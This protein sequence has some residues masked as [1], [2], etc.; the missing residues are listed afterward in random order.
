MEKLAWKEN[1]SE[2]LARQSE[3]YSRKNRFI[4][5]LT[6]SFSSANALAYVCVCFFL[7]QLICSWMHL[8]YWLIRFDMN[9]D[10][11]GYVGTLGRSN[12]TMDS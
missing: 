3:I 7:R 4:A 9:E 11:R 6:W 8:I 10:G 5:C 2:I 1:K 12:P